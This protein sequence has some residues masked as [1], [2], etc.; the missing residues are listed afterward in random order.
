[1]RL[2][3]GQRVG[4]LRTEMRVQHHVGFAQCSLFL[5]VL[6]RLLHLLVGFVER[7]FARSHPLIERWRMRLDR[8]GFGDGCRADV[9]LGG[10]LAAGSTGTLT[11]CTT[12]CRG[13]FLSSTA[14][15]P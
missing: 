6:L 8:L 9:A 1:M 3:L 12:R 15:F 13:F 7:D 11:L 10:E 5:V 2:A 14:F 4:H